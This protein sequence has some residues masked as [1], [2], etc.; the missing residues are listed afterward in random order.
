MLSAKQDASDTRLMHLWVMPKVRVTKRGCGKKVTYPRK[1]EVIAMAD[2]E[3]RIS[4]WWE[5]PRRRPKNGASSFRVPLKASSTLAV[6]QFLFDILEM[7]RK[8]KLLVLVNPFSGRRLAAANWE[9]ARPVFEKAH[10]ELTVVMT[11]RAGHAY[12]IVN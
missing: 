7:P 3:A 11:E 10:V 12:E 2:G 8:R 9:V 6:G 4:S 5:S 1:L